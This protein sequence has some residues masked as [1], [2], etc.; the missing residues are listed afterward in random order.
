M[1][2]DTHLHTRFSTD[3]KMT[4]EEAIVKAKDSHLGL[5]ITEHMDLCYPVAGDFVFSVEDYFTAYGPQRSGDLLLG[6]EIGMR[7]E[8]LAENRTIV[9][10]YDFD[11]VIGSIHVVDNQ[12][13]Y[14]PPYYEGKDKI[15]AYIRYLEVMAQ[16]IEQYS[17][18]DTLGHVDYICRYAPYKDSNIYYSE[19][20]QAFDQVLTALVRKNKA[21]EL[22]TRRLGDEK[23]R[24]ALLPIYTRFAELG[25]KWITIGSDAHR[26]QEIGK[27]FTEA[28]SLIKQIKLEPVYFKQRQPVRQVISER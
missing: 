12:D 26:P 3:S 1:W 24:E 4:L 23:S 10:S 22:N 11:M 25:G 2:F 16:M 9:E 15:K 6:I 5:V 14:Y 7:P 27:H 28:F 13:L 20:S 21:L 17:F 19:F 18:I 8:C